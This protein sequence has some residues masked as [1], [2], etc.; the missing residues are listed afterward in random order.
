MRVVK[1]GVN[2]P[3]ILWCDNVSTFAIASNPFFHACIEHIEVDYH[4]FKRE[5]LD[6]GVA[7]RGHVSSSCHVNL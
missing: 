3:L 7:V 4:F 5:S 6:I 2:T 1:W